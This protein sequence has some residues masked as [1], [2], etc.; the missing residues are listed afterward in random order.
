MAL[1]RQIVTIYKN[2][3]YKTQVL[4]ASVRHPQHVVEAALAGGHICTMPYA[5]FQQLAKHPLTDIG[6]KKFLADWDAM[7]KK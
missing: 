5:V 2:Y 1:I 3:D 4:V 7:G 6:L